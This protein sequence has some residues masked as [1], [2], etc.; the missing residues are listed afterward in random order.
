[1][2]PKKVG[3]DGGSRCGPAWLDDSNVDWGQGLKQLREWLHANARGRQVRLGYFG[4]IPP[5]AYGVSQVPMNDEDL[6]NG[7][8][9]GLYAVSAHIVASTPAVAF[10]ARG[11]GAEWLRERRPVAIVGHAYYI[12]AV[13]GRGS[14]P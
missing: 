12:F 1:N 9:P 5:E 14:S 6:L 8:S 11:S 3:L 13:P 4:T 2:D 10:Q 7:N